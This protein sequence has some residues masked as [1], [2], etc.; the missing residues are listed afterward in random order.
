M[1]NGS[2][3]EQYIEKITTFFLNMLAKDTIDRQLVD[4][5][6]IYSYDPNSQFAKH[7]EESNP[8]L[9]EFVDTLG[10]V[11]TPDTTGERYLYGAKDFL[12]W[13]NEYESER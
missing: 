8:S 6:Y 2:D 4:D 5:W 13:I 1:A 11:I 10:M 7:L 9:A 3:I 12:A